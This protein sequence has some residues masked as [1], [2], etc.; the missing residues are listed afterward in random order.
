MSR[1][2]VCALLTL[3][4]L[5]LPAAAEEAAAPDTLIAAVA[6]GDDEAVARHLGN[7]ETVRTELDPACPPHTRCKPVT[8]AAELGNPTVLRLLL[9]AGAD[10]NGTN[11][12]G[13]NALILAIINGNTQSVDVL[14]QFGANPNQP[15]SFGIS[16]VSGV[17]MQGDTKMLETLLAA[18]GDPNTMMAGGRGKQSG[19]GVPLLCVAAL[20]GQAEVMR[21]LVEHGAD[22]S[23]ANP[24]GR[25]AP[26]CMGRKWSPEIDEVLAGL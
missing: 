13:D 22:R 26:D 20:A 18:G 1:R 10:P 3:G 11:S 5:A 16:A 12:V 14:L 15:N 2:L 24:M 19:M 21:L 4:W 23:M 25:P 9:E 7:P 8:I 17:V 6:R